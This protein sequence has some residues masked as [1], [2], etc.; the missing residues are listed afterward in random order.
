MKAHLFFNTTPNS[1][2]SGSRNKPGELF[3]GINLNDPYSNYPLSVLMH[4]AAHVTFDSSNEK[5]FRDKEWQDAIANDK[6]SISYYAKDYPLTEDLASTLDSY[7]IYRYKPKK[8]S[9]DFRNFLR[10]TMYNRYI[11]LD[12]FDFYRNNN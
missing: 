3:Y 2:S 5:Y 6:F 8:L 12:K 1:N 9:E 11:I 10:R 7:L 4:K